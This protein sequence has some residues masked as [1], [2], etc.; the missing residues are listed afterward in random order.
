MFAS[1]SHGRR[2]P[3]PHAAPRPAASRRACHRGVGPA[4][5]K[6]AAVVLALAADSRRLSLSAAA[7]QPRPAHA[8]EARSARTAPRTRPRASAALRECAACSGRDDGS[9][10]PP[11]TPHPQAW[12]GH[13]AISA[14]YRSTRF[15]QRKASPSDAR[16]ATLARKQTLQLSRTL[17]GRGSH[18]SSRHSVRTRA[19]PGCSAHRTQARKTSTVLF[20]ARTR[21]HGG[22]RAAPA[23]RSRGPSSRL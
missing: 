21:S 11:P 4:G 3:P 13:D 2:R 8:A 14:S 15:R 6:Q 7:A 22:G 23:V 19:P 9:C 1:L 10:A 18:G 5:C 17:R 12:F 20:P 16:F